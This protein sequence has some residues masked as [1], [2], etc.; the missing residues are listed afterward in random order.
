M[1]RA[2]VTAAFADAVKLEE[3]AADSFGVWRGASGGGMRLSANA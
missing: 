2:E 1:A 3:C